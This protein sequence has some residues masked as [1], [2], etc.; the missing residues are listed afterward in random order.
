MCDVLCDPLEM[1][2]DMYCIYIYIF[3]YIIFFILLSKEV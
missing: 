3:D 1:S 2:W